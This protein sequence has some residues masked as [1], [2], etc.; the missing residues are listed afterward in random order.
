MFLTISLG[1]NPPFFWQ[2][3]CASVDKKNKPGRLLPPLEFKLHKA[4]DSQGPEG[5]L[6]FGTC[7]QCPF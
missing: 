4:A 1:L 6:F 5:W 3:G 7:K 2:Y